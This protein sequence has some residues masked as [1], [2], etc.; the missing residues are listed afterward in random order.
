MRT[1]YIESLLS[2]VDIENIIYTLKELQ[3]SGNFVL[4]QYQYS[5]GVGD[6]FKAIFS[7]PEHDKL[8]NILNPYRDLQLELPFKIFLRDEIVGYCSIIDFEG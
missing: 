2:S 5:E 1:T 4:Q 8:V 6:E 7:K 3:F